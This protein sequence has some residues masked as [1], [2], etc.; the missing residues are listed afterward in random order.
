MSKKSFYCWYLGFTNAYSLQGYNRILEL[1]QLILNYQ[2][3]KNLTSAASMMANAATSP[4]KVTL[5]LNENTLT[6]VDTHRVVS[7]GG[8]SGGQKRSST[9]SRDSTSS[10]SFKS[11]MLNY[12]NITYVT[13][14]TQPNYADIVT[15]IVRSA[16][17]NEPNKI[18]LNLH[19]FRFDSESTAIKMEQYFNFYRTQFWK[20]YEKQQLK[21]QKQQ[22]AARKQ[23][24]K[25]TQ[26]QQQQRPSSPSDN[27]H[28]LNG[29]LRN[30]FLKRLLLKIL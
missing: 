24:K 29:K 26:Q 11:Y 28:L 17:P 25:Q 19:A 13:R 7:S 5:Q 3:E 18:M 20:K 21:L 12:E 4:A 1:V 8:G 15:C 22:M 6:I 23:N 2:N 27:E 16:L 10:G 9:K 30:S 14:L